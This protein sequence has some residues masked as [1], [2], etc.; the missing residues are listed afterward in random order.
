MLMPAYRLGEG[1]QARQ[2][3]AALRKTNGRR[4]GSLMNAV[5]RACSPL[6]ARADTE[7]IELGRGNRTRAQAAR[8]QV[9]AA[10]L[11]GFHA[12]TVGRGSPR[13]SRSVTPR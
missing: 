13:F 12:P 7:P 1:A 10:D 6:S 5:P 8:R 3:R 4:L 11:E 2:A 9:L